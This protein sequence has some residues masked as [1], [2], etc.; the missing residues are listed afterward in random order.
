MLDELQAFLDAA[1]LPVTTVVGL[2]PATP[3]TCVALVERD[4]VNPSQPIFSGSRVTY[5]RV[6]LLSRSVNYSL[7]RLNLDLVAGRLTSIAN[8]VIG[9]TL[10]LSSDLAALPAWVGPADD[11]AGDVLAAEL[12][13]A[14]VESV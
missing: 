13:L 12:E 10:Y 8:Q 14:R 1:A 7:A 2:F 4:S 5:P 9:D 11:D 6:E 3:Y